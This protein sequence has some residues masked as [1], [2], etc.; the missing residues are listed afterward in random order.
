ML[1]DNGPLP[2]SKILPLSLLLSDFHQLANV[3]SAAPVEKDL[4]L[5]YWFWEKE[6]FS[7]L[8][9]TVAP[10]CSVASYTTE[11]FA[12]SPTLVPETESNR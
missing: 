1:S 11:P 2:K 5:I 7:W 12:V 10:F 8:L 3:K 4:M 6:S 9:D